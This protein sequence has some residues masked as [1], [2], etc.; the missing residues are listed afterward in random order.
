MSYRLSLVL[1]SFCAW[2]PFTAVQAQAASVLNVS[3]QSILDLPFQPA[4]LTL[5]YGENELQFGKLWR[6]LGWNSAE[7]PPLVIF[8]HGGCWL[9]AFSID[10][11]FALTSALAQ[12]GF[13][14]WSIEYR[15]TGDDGG[16]WPG[17]FEDVQAGIDF[18]L[19]QQ[20]QRFDPKRVFIVGHSAGGHLAILAAQKHQGAVQAIG[21]AAITDIKEYGAGKNSCQRAV[22][23][24]MGGTVAQ[25]G[26]EYK[27]ATPVSFQYTTLIHG[28]AD[29]I[30]PVQQSMRKSKR[31]LL[32]NDAG[33]FD[34]LHPDSAAYAAL[35]SVITP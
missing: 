16:G 28:S 12:Q 23:Q 29:K 17:T 21:L 15:R 13:L 32:I 3:Y 11:S 20:Q 14:V 35:I 4:D 18:I 7:A 31:K 30:V 10:H 5:S 2:L 25:K 34:F 8:I 22:T 9:N 27:Q 1:L 6:P 33:H 19:A 24:F 26:S